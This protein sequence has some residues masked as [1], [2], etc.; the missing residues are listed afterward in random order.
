MEHAFSSERPVWM[1]IGACVLNNADRTWEELAT[2]YL[3]RFH[4]RH[5]RR[6]NTV[7]IHPGDA[8]VSH[9]KGSS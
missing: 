5:R 7:R 1:V 2:K 6:D 9:E 4:V 3:A 8:F